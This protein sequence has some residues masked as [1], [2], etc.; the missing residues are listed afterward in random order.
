MANITIQVQSMLNTATYD[1]YTVSDAIT[2]STLKTTIQA[3]TGFNPSWFNL[4]F[5]YE[6]LSDTDVLATKGIVNGSVIR[7]INVI[8]SLSSKE[9]RQKAKL[10]LAA[11]DRTASGNPRDS[12]D[13][14]ELP[15][16][17]SGN[18]VV[19]NPNVGGLVEGR[20]WN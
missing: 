18:T 19:D 16:Q 1:S 4:Y 11:L 12:F 8:R 13:I 7:T 17:Y 14:T 2:V 6:T 9:D 15:T 20:P 5:Q 3:A 10:A